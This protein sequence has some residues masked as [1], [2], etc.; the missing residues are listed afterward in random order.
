MCAMLRCRTMLVLDA[1]SP[2]GGAELDI[3]LTDSVIRFPD[4][5]GL[6]F[7]YSWGKILRSESAHVFRVM[8]NHPEVA[9]RG[10]KRG[11]LPE[12]SGEILETGD[13]GSIPALHTSDGTM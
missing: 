7:N 11:R 2:K 1:S 6:I 5:I 8:R 12:G 9:W 10:R 4:D 3:T 13:S